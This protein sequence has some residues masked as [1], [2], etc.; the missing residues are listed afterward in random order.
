M[1]NV[2]IFRLPFLR[3]KGFR[4][5]RFS[6]SG[7]G[8]AWT[9]FVENYSDPPAGSLDYYSGSKKEGLE[10]LIVKPLTNPRR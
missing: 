3:L 10:L 5:A 6:F 2:T 7:Q 1:K 8:I 9:W 4:S